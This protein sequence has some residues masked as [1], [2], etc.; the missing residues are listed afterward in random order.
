MSASEDDQV[1]DGIRV[2]IAEAIERL[3]AADAR[4]EAL[5]TFS[6][7]GRRAL[8]FTKSARMHP[9][10]RVWR[11]GVF[12]LDGEG[13]LRATASFTR[14]VEQGRSNHQSASAEVRREYRAAASN[15]PF[16][17]GESINFDAEVIPLEAD[18]LS[19]STGPL[20]LRDGR[21]LVRWSGAADDDAAVEFAAYLADRIDLLVNP[22]EGA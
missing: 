1:V 20:F 13:T 21:A 7:A 12:L 14:A 8:V 5:A 9:A 2:T 15:G 22:P 3:R 19:V 16:P 17:A 18:Y 10:G 6:P 11:L 4:D